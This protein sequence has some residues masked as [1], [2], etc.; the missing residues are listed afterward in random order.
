MYTYM[1]QQSCN[2][3]GREESGNKRQNLIE[4][5][6]QTSVQHQAVKII[7]VSR[8]K[9]EPQTTSIIRI[10]LPGTID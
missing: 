3:S 10:Q 1:G 8:L 7:S 9:V 4:T 2:S 5:K 6:S